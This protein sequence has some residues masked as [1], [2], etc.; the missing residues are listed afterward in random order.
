MNA[1]SEGNGIQEVRVA[2]LEEQAVTTVDHFLAVRTAA[3]ESGTIE[4]APDYMPVRDQLE[5]ALD[6][7][8]ELHAELTRVVSGGEA[9]ESAAAEMRAVLDACLVLEFD[10]TARRRERLERL[11]ERR[12][13]GQVGFIDYWRKRWWIRFR[14][15]AVDAADLAGRVQALRERASRLTVPSAPVSKLVGDLPIRGLMADGRYDEAHVM[16][17]ALLRRHRGNKRFVRLVRDL[18]VKRGSLTAVL[19]LSRRLEA[20]D[21]VSR[22][23]LRQVEGRVRELS[24]WFPRV[25]GPFARFDAVDDRTVLHLV[26]E[27]RPYLSNGFT[28]RS[29]RNFLAEVAAG[30]R[31]VVLTE[32]GF[33]RHNGIEAFAEVEI[34]DG[35]EH[36]RLDVGPDDA[37]D[38]PCDM[39]LEQF[40][41]RAYK[42]LLEVRPAVLHVSS[43]RR[44]YET[45]L[46]AL[47][48]KHKTGVPL[49]YEV[50]SFFEGLWTPESA[51]EETGEVFL[52]RLATEQMCMAAADMV[53]TLGTSMR[54]ELIA[55]GIPADKIR[56]VPNGVDVDS[57]SPRQRAHALAEQL[58]IGDAPTFGYVSNMDHHRE[59]QDTLIHAV[60]SLRAAGSEARCVLVGGGPRLEELSALATSLG[61]SDRVVFTGPVDHTEITDYY[62]LIDIFVVPRIDERAAR[63]VTPLKPFEAMALGKPVVASDLPAL[64]EI[65]DP[66]HRG[67]VFPPGDH[68]A[69]ARTLLSLFDDESERMRSGEAG[70]AWVQAER[71]WHMNGPRYREAFAEAIARAEMKSHAG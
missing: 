32:P 37:R 49:V 51:H 43:G 10:P 42:Q 17:R 71:Q 40:A 41:Q 7:I 54:D 8:S 3:G 30:L 19:A 46:V 13:A 22:Y 38:V 66:P 27:S 18:E 33:P 36:R 2:R 4:G 28:S 53:L 25:P 55:R 59:S 44:G 29:H 34:I 31:P 9:A 65:V 69:L 52:R 12:T 50:R 24:G 45:A 57:F 15:E 63:Y 56:L 39:W 61:V 64:R 62:S 67:H 47:A 1:L 68:A 21:K 5:V 48:L 26:K 23:S 35:I 60:S 58:G 6:Q 14:S 16:A 70:L 20:L 11:S